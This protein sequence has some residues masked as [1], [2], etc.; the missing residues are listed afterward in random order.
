MEGSD[1]F[2]EVLEHMRKDLEAK[3]TEMA[4]SGLIYLLGTLNIR[5]EYIEKRLGEKDHD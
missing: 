3:R 2:R 5:L 4:I 1:R